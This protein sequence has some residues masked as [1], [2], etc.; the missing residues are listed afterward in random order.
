MNATAEL[1]IYAWSIIIVRGQLLQSLL[2]WRYAC[3]K[4]PL[5]PGTIRRLVHTHTVKFKWNKCDVIEQRQTVLF[6]QSYDFNNKHHQDIQI[7][8]MLWYAF[9]L[10]CIALTRDEAWVQK[11]MCLCLKYGATVQHPRALL[12]SECLH[13]MSD[14]LLLS[15]IASCR[16]EIPY[17]HY[18]LGWNTILLLIKTNINFSPIRLHWF[19]LNTTFFLMFSNPHKSI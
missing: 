13:V 6:Y 9:F 8:Y 15:P 10:N 19:I 5:L 4:L 14:V 12:I 2:H 11:K 1:N 7:A 17:H 3:V 18:P 16:N